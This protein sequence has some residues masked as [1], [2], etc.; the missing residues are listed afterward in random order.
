MKTNQSS[1]IWSRCCDGCKVA[2]LNGEIMGI[3]IHENDKEITFNPGRD[4]HPA[5]EGKE[6][7]AGA[8]E[9]VR[10]KDFSNYCMPV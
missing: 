4:L 9:R 3:A 8:P 6:K 10:V 2:L 7:A 5:D 1:L